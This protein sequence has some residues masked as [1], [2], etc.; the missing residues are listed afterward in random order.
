MVCEFFSKEESLEGV[1]DKVA[2]AQSDAR[3]DEDACKDGEDDEYDLGKA[4]LLEYEQDCGRVDQI[5]CDARDAF[6]DAGD[7]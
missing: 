7:S 6:I 1:W 4:E 3:Y 2:Y 5:F